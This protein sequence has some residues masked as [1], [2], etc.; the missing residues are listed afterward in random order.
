MKHSNLGLVLPS[1][2]WQS[3]IKLSV[4]TMQGLPYQHHKHF[5]LLYEHNI[6]IEKKI[7]TLA[8]GCF[9]ASQV[10]S[11]VGEIQVINYSAE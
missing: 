7:I 4:E 11:T 8:L 3:L 9:W 10:P 1:G 5:N 2:G 6:N